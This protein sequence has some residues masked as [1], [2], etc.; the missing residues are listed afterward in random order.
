MESR[1]LDTAPGSLGLIFSKISIEMGPGDP[2]EETGAEKGRRADWEEREGE[3]GRL[4]EE[5][6]GAEEEKGG[7]GEGPAADAA[8]E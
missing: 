8:E 6:E 5:D 7:P 4:E 1:I 2:G 3:D